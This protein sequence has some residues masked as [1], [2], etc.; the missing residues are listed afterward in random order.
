MRKNQLYIGSHTPGS[1]YTTKLNPINIRPLFRNELLSVVETH[2]LSAVTA[3]SF[4]TRFLIADSAGYLSEIWAM[5]EGNPNPCLNDARIA[6]T[7][8]RI[9]H[10]I[11]NILTTN[12]RT[13]HETAPETTHELNTKPCTNSARNSTRNHARI[14]H[15]LS[16]KQHPKPRTNSARNS[17]R[18]HARIKHELSTKQ[19]PKPRTNSARIY[20][21]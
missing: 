14:K 12:A 10:L 13:Q 11:F 1:Q 7:T 19:H 3:A 2:S 8:T 4:N 21:A 17:T 18:N 9:K 20:T 15:E 16:T 5:S 6:A